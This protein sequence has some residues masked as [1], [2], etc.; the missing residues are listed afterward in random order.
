MGLG[1]ELGDGVAVALAVGVGESVAAGAIVGTVVGD[2]AGVLTAV[3]GGLVGGAAPP[4]TITPGEE[5]DPGSEV[6]VYRPGAR[7]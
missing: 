3:A 7:E 5:A 4:L 6:R 1:L 2:G